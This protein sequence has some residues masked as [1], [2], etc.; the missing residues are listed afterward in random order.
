[1]GF[2]SL[3][4]ELLAKKHD[5]CVVVASPERPE[6]FDALKTLAGYGARFVLVGPRE[7]LKSSARAIGLEEAVIV[8]A[9]DDVDTANKAVAAVDAE[10]NALLMKGRIKTAILMRAVVH[11]KGG[12]RADKLLSHLA[13][14]ERPDGRYL[15]VTDGGLNIN[16]TIDHKVEIIRNAVDYFKVLGYTKP[17]VALLSGVEVLNPAMRSTTEAAEISAMAISGTFPSAIVGGPMAFDLA[18]SPNACKAK[19][20]GG[21]IR[22]DADILVVP[23]IVSG[24]ILGKSLSYAAGYPSGGLVLGAT[25]PI[26]LLSRADTPV[27][28]INSFLLGAKSL[29]ESFESGNG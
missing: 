8:D 19:N 24:N 6:I 21:K 28:K 15:G 3:G 20:Y 22:G 11:D 2:D 25:K 10:K 7:R 23:E 13:V 27:E 5:L 1:M 18:F 14:F 26:I 16:P 9:R 17:K 29:T 12:L 4:K